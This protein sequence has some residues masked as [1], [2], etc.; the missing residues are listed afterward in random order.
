[1]SA[2]GG[3]FSAAA[4]SG[5]AWATTA[6]LVALTI[7]SSPGAGVLW[8]GVVALAGVV[9]GVWLFRAT[10]RGRRLS[11]RNALHAIYYGL[12]VGWVVPVGLVNIGD[13]S[14]QAWAPHRNLIAQFFVVPGVLGLAAVAELSRRGA[15]SVVPLEPPERLVVTGPFAYLA[16]P[17]Q[18]AKVLTLLAWAVFAR[19]WTVL[20]AAILVLG[21]GTLVTAP[22]E[23]RALDRKLGAEHRRYRAS[24]RA[25]WP[26][27]RPWIDQSSACARLELASACD[28]CGSLGRWVKSQSP[29]G[30]IVV[31][32]PQLQRM[33]YV[34]PGGTSHGVAALCHALEHVHLGWAL[35]GWAVRLPLMRNVA[36]AIYAA[37][38]PRDARAPVACARGVERRRSV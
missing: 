10:R 25:W 38:V 26:R 6:V 29:R 34:G 14:L 28:P 18:S 3:S 21:V 27:W 30:L 32:T 36:E 19:S 1:M 11:T 12:L 33:R 7:G 5:L 17:I 20:A 22:L 16:N 9:P 31:A 24:V 8:W 13:G 4:L 37:S 35:F 15:A 23:R 2:R